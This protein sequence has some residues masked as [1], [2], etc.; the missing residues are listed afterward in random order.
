MFMKTT[1]TAVDP[2]VIDAQI[3]FPITSCLDKGR[4]H[5]SQGLNIPDIQRFILSTMAIFREDEQMGTRGREFV[6][7]EDMSRR[8]KGDF[9]AGYVDVAAGTEAIT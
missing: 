2:T 6:K 4:K 7:C 1:T 8:E 5:R 3:P 9:I